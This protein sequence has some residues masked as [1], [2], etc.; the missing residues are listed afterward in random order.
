MTE[1]IVRDWEQNRAVSF[2]D[3]ENGAWF[4][5]KESS[6]WNGDRVICVKANEGYFHLQRR[7]FYTDIVDPNER[8]VIPINKVI[9]DVR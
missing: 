5:W 3:L 4:F 9:V 7:E 6:T 1:M 8:M 2:A